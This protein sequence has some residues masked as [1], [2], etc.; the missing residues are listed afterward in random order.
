MNNSS[1]F[2]GVFILLWAIFLA[3][4]AAFF[5]ID[6]LIAI[7]AATALPVA[8]MGVAV[9]G[10]KL[11]GA[12]LLY[13]YWDSSVFSK[14]TKRYLLSAVIVAMLIT[15]LGIFGFLYKGH[16]EQEAPIAHIELQIKGKE[17]EVIH[18]QAAN[19]Q[20][21]INLSQLDRGLDIA[22]GK[23]QAS[24]AES[25]RSSQ[26]KERENLLKQKAQNNAAILAIQKDILKIKQET[27][28]A[29]VKLGPIKAIA[30]TIPG[31]NTGTAVKILVM[32]IWYCFDPLAIALEIWGVGLIDQATKQKA[33]KRE[34]EEAE[35]RKKEEEEEERLRKEAEKER[36]RATEEKR[37]EA[38]ER[39]S[40]M[41]EQRKL[42]E[43]EL[44]NKYKKEA[45]ELR[46][47][48]ESLKDLNENSQV[49]LEE[50]IHLKNEVQRKEHEIDTLVQEIQKKSV[51]IK[52]LIDEEERLAE[53]I[54]EIEH[55]KQQ[56]E[57][58]E[59]Q[60]TEELENQKSSYQTLL[61]EK[62]SL[63]TNINDLENQLAI[64]I[65]EQE[66]LSLLIKELED[67]DAEIIHV[68]D[69]EA[70]DE[71]NQ[72]TADNKSLEEH[73]LKLTEQIE[74]LRVSMTV[75]E[76][77]INILNKDLE[78]KEEALSK[79]SI[80]TE[81]LEILQ[82]ELEAKNNELEKSQKE[83]EARNI[84]LEVRNSELEVLCEALERKATKANQYDEDLREAF[85]SND[86]E[87]VLAIME[88]KP[89][90]LDDI[91]GIVTNYQQEKLKRVSKNIE[92]NVES[93]ERPGDFILKEQDAKVVVFEEGTD[94]TDIT[95][96]KLVVEIMDNINVN[97][98]DEHK[99]N[100][101]DLTEYNPDEGLL[102]SKSKSKSKRVKKGK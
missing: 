100:E 75:K 16:F 78:E 1:T 96:D 36:K 24:K 51:E 29:T 49:F 90:I 3:S 72:L 7:F 4:V 10:G 20:I 89:E 63:E 25:L 31:T 94:D 81:E 39:R 58:F 19:K 86:K 45:E 80:T 47:Q 56:K 28:A 30:D 37:R 74:S 12:I 97:I 77:T 32:L 15:A 65:T 91:I 27:A 99:T 18:F 11:I 14:R 43:L 38:I 67:R 26:K 101:S 8:I 93:L 85:Y 61:N 22:L 13:K 44:N 55:I 57:Q 102:S 50:N 62:S 92:E 66:R 40:E 2:L 34:A 88:K 95:N 59:K 64:H 6:G 73:I 42:L 82:A 48:L 9:E 21:E 23:D 84:E 33:L 53:L 60:T 69:E 17:E 79:P 46:I 41:Q 87:R 35:R 5:S 76:E 98:L 71:I 54:V 68:R 52:N 70:I 83:I